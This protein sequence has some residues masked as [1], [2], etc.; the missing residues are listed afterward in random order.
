MVI[1]EDFLH[2]LWNYKLFDHTNLKTTHGEE[3]K[4]ISSGIVNNNSGPD[5]F[6]AKLIINEQ[7]WAGNVEIHVKASDWYLH[8]HENDTNYDNVILHVV[9]Q[10]DV[11][12]YRKNN[13]VIP[14][15]ELQE[16]TSK[17]YIFN[18][19]KLFSKRLKYIHCENDISSIDDFILNNWIESLYI[20]KLVLKSDLILGLLEQTNKDWESV[21]FKLLSK[22]FGLKV[23]GESFLNLANSFDFSVLRK[24]RYRLKNIEALL[25]GQAGFLSK[26]QENIYYQT[27][28]KEYQF[29]TLKYELEPLFKGQFQFFRLRPNN[30]PTIRIAQLANL[31]FSHTNLFSKIIDLKNPNDFYKLFTVETSVFWESHYNFNSSSKRLNKKLTRSFIDLIL[32]NTILP[33]LFVFYK[34]QGKSEEERIFKLIKKIKPEKNSIINEFKSLNINVNN[35][36]ESQAVLHL[37]N[38]YGDKNSCLEC[39]IGNAL[40][41]L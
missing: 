26:N 15:L 29:I 6:N 7:T 14:T 11:E 8:H 23:N 27:L 31:Y 40:L 37:K 28:K 24:E 1:R 33:L 25:F 21:L 13:T 32:I 39:A 16:F 17:K 20:E 18:Y 36:F 22:N 34:Q 38:N 10:H 4:V 12:V 9:W 5:F 3:I 35:A 2:Y 41:R 30:F 19:H